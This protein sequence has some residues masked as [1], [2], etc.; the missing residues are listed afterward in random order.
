MNHYLMVSSLLGYL[1]MQ[2]GFLRLFN[3]MQKKFAKMKISFVFSKG[4][5]HN[6]SITIK[7]TTNSTNSQL[8]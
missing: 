1:P 4:W 2:L 6:H 3:T 7:C 8:W 5:T